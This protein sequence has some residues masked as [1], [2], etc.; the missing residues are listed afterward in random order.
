MAYVDV[1]GESSGQGVKM[2]IPEGLK[3]SQL[4]SLERHRVTA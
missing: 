4:G 3:Q 2:A 1:I